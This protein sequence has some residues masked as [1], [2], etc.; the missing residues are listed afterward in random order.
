MAVDIRLQLVTMLPRLRRFAMALSRSRDLADDLVQATC[1]RALRGQQGWQ[2]GTRL[3]SWLYRIMQN[4]WIDEMRKRKG[5]GRAQPV[6]ASYDLVGEDGERSVEAR[7]AAAEVMQALET[8]PDEQRAIVSLVCV[9]D[10]SYREV[11]D[12]LEIPIGTVM[13]RL[14]RARAALVRELGLDAGREAL[15]SGRRA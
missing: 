13:S 9:E 10:L 6:E 7:L 12:T 1:E 5:Q 8:L 3:D 2:P 15:Q 11:A 4:I 14:S